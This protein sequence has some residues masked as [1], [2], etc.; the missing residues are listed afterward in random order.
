MQ[1]MNVSAILDE[2][3]PEI[4]HHVMEVVKRDTAGC[5]PNLIQGGTGLSFNISLK[6]ELGRRCDLYSVTDTIIDIT[7][8]TAIEGLNNTRLDISLNLD[9]SCESKWRP[10]DIFLPGLSDDCVVIIRFD[11]GISCP[12]IELF[13]SDAAAFSHG[14]E[15]KRTVFLKFFENLSAPSNSV[16][17][18]VDNYLKQMASVSDVSNSCNEIVNMNLLLLYFLVC[19]LVVF[20][21]YT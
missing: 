3:K 19:H 13:L 7:D 15:A 12:Q 1:Q 4:V 20:T 6:F 11:N 17:V 18:C 16:Y 5:N 21:C 14:Q 9:E 10:V 8:I 2:I